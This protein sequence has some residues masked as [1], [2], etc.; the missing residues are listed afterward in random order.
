MIKDFPE[1]HIPNR[2]LPT[3]AIDTLI[4]GMPQYTS[5]QKIW[6]RAVAIAMC[7]QARGWTEAE[8]LT[9]FMSRPQR[10]NR[11]G[12]KRHTNHRLWEQIQAYSKHGNSGRQEL[13][14]A[15]KQAKVNRLAGEGLTT[16]E[17]LVNNAIGT[18]WAWEDRLAEGR[19]NLSV[20]EA[21]VM[22]YVIAFVE[23]RRMARVTCPLREVGAYANIPKTTVSRTLQ[24]L[25]EKGFL[26]RFS[27]GIWSKKPGNRKAAIY[28]LGDPCNLRYGG[29]GTPSVVADIWKRFVADRDSEE[30]VRTRERGVC[31]WGHGLAPQPRLLRSPIEWDIGV[32][33][34]VSYVPQGHPYG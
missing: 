27:R 3:W 12:Q 7:M 11:A 21:A 10:K 8:Y 9:E 34:R 6:G 28:S 16:P 17:D 31:V 2:A 15:W 4:F 24:S 5:A 26:V 22:A 13:E 25:V 20:A 19:D 14:K 23:K 1:Q 30:V 18:A 29:R 33:P 32:L